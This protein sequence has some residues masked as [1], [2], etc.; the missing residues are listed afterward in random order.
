MNLNLSPPTSCGFPGV[1]P[2]DVFQERSVA[3]SDWELVLRPEQGGVQVLDLDEI[4][5]V[6]IY[7]CHRWVLR[8]P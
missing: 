7:I 3:T 4:D 8:A 5:D 2:I 6:E 1:D